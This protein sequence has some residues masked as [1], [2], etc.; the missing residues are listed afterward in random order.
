MSRSSAPSGRAHGFTLLEMMVSSVIMVLVLGGIAATFI[1][2][3]RSYQHES[4]VKMATE[5]A[6][7]A[8]AYLDR[9][10]KMAGYGLDPRF[11][12]DFGTFGGTLVK[13]N[14]VVPMPAGVPPVVT[15]DLAFRYRNP[16]YLRRGSLNGNTLTLSGAP[17]TLGVPI[18]T[19]QPVLIA[20]R[21]GNNYLVARAAANTVAGSTTLGLIDHGPPFDG[22][23][24]LPLLAGAPGCAT[25]QNN[26]AFVMLIHEV[27]VRVISRGTPGT[28]LRSFLVVFNSH[29]D[30]AN[31]T[32]FD[33]IAADVE[34]FQ[35]AYVMNRDPA[36]VSP[37]YSPG[38]NWILGD[39]ENQLPDRT[40]LAP[41]MESPYT[42]PN[43]YTAHPANIR[44]VR[45]SVVARSQRTPV[46][47]PTDPF[48]VENFTPAS[49]LFDG[50]YRST[51]LSSVRL[52]NML[53]RS[54]FTPP[55]REP[56]DTRDL[57]YSGG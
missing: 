35:V 1:A 8:N 27:R 25:D 31:N 7:Q 12:F 48:A 34:S 2:T 37:A 4:Q 18:K 40:A 45:V 46:R 51:T 22:S 30:P 19:G 41:L 33:P 55:L 11:A 29:A 44:Q 42:D 14:A 36:A 20:C 10:V 56:V 57:N 3:Q 32:D 52:P 16:G 43:R 47:A 13:D 26:P 6:R 49:L 28:P 21:G 54:F 38:G 17:N 9:L 24:G 39:A 15:D 50:Y 5:N 53:S 23:N